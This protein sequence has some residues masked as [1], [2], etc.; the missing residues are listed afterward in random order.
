MSHTLLP[1]PSPPITHACHQS[2]LVIIYHMVSGG[3]VQ[4]SSPRLLLN[5]V[6]LIGWNYLG[7]VVLSYVKHG[8]NAS[9][10]DTARQIFLWD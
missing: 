1:P 4:R 9:L 6:R 3:S 7:T 10:I 8:L 5:V 2:E